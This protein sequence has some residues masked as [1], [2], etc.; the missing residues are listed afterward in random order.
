MT[1]LRERQKAGRRK[2]IL[3][4]AS[5]LFR[6]D[7]FGATSIEQI[8]GRARREVGPAGDLIDAGRSESIA[9]EEEAGGGEDVLAPAGLLPLSQAGHE[10]S[11]FMGHSR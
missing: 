4:A 9:P 10:P 6:R 7:G 5:L 1:G 3:A 11:Q 8:A 2:D